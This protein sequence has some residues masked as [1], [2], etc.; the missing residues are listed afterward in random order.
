MKRTRQK[1]HTAAL[2]SATL[3][4][5]AAAVLS[6][7]SS[8]VDDGPQVDWASDVCDSVQDVGSRLT[9]PASDHKDAKK[10]HSEVVTFMGALDR[11]L[12]ALDGKMRKEGAP[13]VKGGDAAYKKALANLRAAR[14]K[15][16]GTTAELKKAD[17]T[18]EK[19]LKAALKKAADGLERAGAYQGPAQDFRADPALKR[20][21]DKAPECS[22]LNGAGHSAASA[23]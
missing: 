13:P 19:S 16:D 22:G 5:V 21:F 17:V 6:G 23:G 1:R 8:R 12:G 4:V 9:L 10:Y 11:Q 7:C 18:D 3:G 14:G 15:L 2:L 20:A